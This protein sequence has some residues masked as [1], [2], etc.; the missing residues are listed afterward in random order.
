VAGLAVRR[1]FGIDRAI[2][3]TCD[4]ADL[5]PIGHRIEE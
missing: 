5:L 4:L 2:E 3:G 1:E